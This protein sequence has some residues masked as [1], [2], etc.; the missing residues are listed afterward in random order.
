MKKLLK[1]LTLM[2][3]VFSITSAVEASTWWAY[4]L[5]PS[6][7]IETITA[8]SYDGYNHAQ[9]TWQNNTGTATL[10]VM[11][12]SGTPQVYYYADFYTYDF[13]IYFS[14]DGVN[15]QYMATYNY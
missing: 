7:D 8:S 14:Y 6:Y 2:F 13:D 10:T 3:I 1:I 11:S 5:D 4:P 9:I 15:W 12:P